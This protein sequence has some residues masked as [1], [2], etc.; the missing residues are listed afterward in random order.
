MPPG[1]SLVSAEDLMEWLV[2]IR[3]LDDN[4]IYKDETYLLRLRFNKEYPIGR[5]TNVQSPEPN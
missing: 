1:I 2:E 3:V 4:P 5:P